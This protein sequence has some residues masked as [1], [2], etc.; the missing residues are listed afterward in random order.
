MNKVLITGGAGFIGSHLAEQLI[1]LGKEVYIID[2]LTTG[3][4]PN[5][6]KMKLKKIIISKIVE[7]DI[8][9]LRELISK[10]DCV[11]H[12]AA[13]VG[14]FNV[15]KNPNYS[16]LNNINSSNVIFSLCS[17]LGKRVLFTSSSEVYPYNSQ[18]P[19]K[20][21]QT[22]NHSFLRPDNP[23]DGYAISKYIGESLLYN[24]QQLDFVIARLFNTVGPRQLPNYGMVVPRLITKALNNEN[25]IVYGDGK[26]TRTFCYVKDT[27]KMLIK[28]MD[29]GIKRDVFN[30]G[31]CKEISI[32]QLAR[33]IKMITRSKS[34]IIL[35]SYKE[36]YGDGF[37]DT[38]RRVP[39]FNK[40]RLN[41]SDKFISNLYS[42]HETIVR[43][44]E[45]WQNE[46][47]NSV[48]YNN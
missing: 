29:S 27:V 45:W 28:L 7:S 47:I 44:I 42:Y 19:I 33:D 41:V 9:S 3:R 17:E 2:D 20:E 23:K 8:D 1:S 11:Y 39:D 48:Y 15:L 36:K 21:D 16:I 31:A 10:V 40:F 12:L 43:T 14:F 32:Y 22:I 5:I 24:D 18:M 46:G 26:Q 6:S 35:K 37:I 38:N 13:S 34:E 30:I 4:Y 25:I